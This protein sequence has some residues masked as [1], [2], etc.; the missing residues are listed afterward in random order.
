MAMGVKAQIFQ[1][2]YR[3]GPKLDYNS[4]TSEIPGSSQVI[5]TKEAH[6][7]LSAGYFVFN[8]LELGIGL[9]Y[10]SILCS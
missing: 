10:S 8:N 6:L 7:G 1:R 2:T 4:S 5:K 3:F 9:N